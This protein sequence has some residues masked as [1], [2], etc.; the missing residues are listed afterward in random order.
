MSSIL[1]MLAHTGGSRHLSYCDRLT[2]R[3]IGDKCQV[4]VTWQGKSAVVDGIIQAVRRDIH[5]DP[6]EPNE[7]W[8]VD[9]L[10]VAIADCDYLLPCYE[11]EGF[12]NLQ[13]TQ[14]IGRD[15]N[16][17]LWMKKVGLK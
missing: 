16:Y 15:K 2:R 4:V 6:M 10:Q 1:D 7:Y 14:S 3:K 13:C 11:D 5:S 9:I 17:K 12:P 8:Y